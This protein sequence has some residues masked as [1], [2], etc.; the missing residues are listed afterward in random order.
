MDPQSARGDIFKR[1]L[2]TDDVEG[3]CTIYPPGTMGGECDFTP[4]GGLDLDCSG[5]GCSAS[6]RGAGWAVA[7]LLLFSGRRRTL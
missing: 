4:R 5:E 6:G 2:R 7:L 1:I 3:I